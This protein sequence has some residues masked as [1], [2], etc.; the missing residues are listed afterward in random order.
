MQGVLP[1]KIACILVSRVLLELY[2]IGIIDSF[3]ASVV[4]LGLQVNGYCVSQI[5]WLISLIWP[6]STLNKDSPIG[7]DVGHFSEAFLYLFIKN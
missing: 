7:Y 2:T 4:D 1:G 5:T 6:A 3:L